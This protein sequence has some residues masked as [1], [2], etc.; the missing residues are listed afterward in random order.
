MQ[1]NLIILGILLLFLLFIFV[2]YPFLGLAC[3]LIII[4]AEDLFVIS[5]RTFVFY[6]GII[7]VFGWFINLL[8][9]VK[10]P[11][12]SVKPTL[13]LLIFI[14]WAGISY[15]WAQD[16]AENLARWASLIQFYLLYII[17]QDLLRIKRRLSILSVAYFISAV[18]CSIFAIKIGLALGEG[19]ISLTEA[20]NADF[21]SQSLGVDF[22]LL[23]YIFKNIKGH[24]L[25]RL[26]L[27]IGA[28]L[29][30]IAVIMTGSR[31]TY[32]AFLGTGALIWLIS[33]RKISKLITS[34][35][36][37]V[38]III[39]LNLVY[40]KG[41]IS[42]YI[43]KERVG[44][45]FHI[46]DPGSGEKRLNILIVGLEMIKSNP[47]IGVGLG[48]F[49][50]RF[51]D[52]VPAASHYLPTFLGIEPGRGPHNMFLSVQSELGIVGSFLFFWFF[53]SI[54]KKLWP[55][56]DKIE[57]AT[58]IILLIFIFL[59]GL[60]IPMQDIKA[61]WFALGLATAIPMII[62]DEAKLKSEGLP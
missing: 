28:F 26:L 7:V 4:P 21:F 2:L 27:A 41:I 12:F 50:A 13:L 20:Q 47:I 52:Y 62:E 14:F 51:I 30:L 10:Q 9:K 58:G 37:G 48:N 11:R 35:L 29:I 18:I 5:N 34:L 61:F 56:K 24:S 31:G 59:G 38:V 36:I 32:A 54:L 19:R 44:T 53:W 33:R 46:N 15:F 8:T 60:T 55:Y 3:A 39:A 57:G 23:P 25:L 45:T 43:L 42:E 49:S 16:K 22:L 6:L 1:I 17:M 40:Q